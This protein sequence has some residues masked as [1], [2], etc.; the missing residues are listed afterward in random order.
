MELS[1]SSEAASCAAT[2]ELSNILWNPKVHYYF[3]KSPPLAPILRQI[4]PV[5]TTQAY[6]KYILILINICINRI[7][8]ERLYI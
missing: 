8:R 1:P 4:N 2:Q 6:L 3:H 5:Y 7:K